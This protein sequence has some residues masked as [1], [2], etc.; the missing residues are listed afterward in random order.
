MQYLEHHGLGELMF[1]NMNM[2]F[3]ESVKRE[4]ENPNCARD[5]QA[6]PDSCGGWGDLAHHYVV[7]EP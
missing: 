4:G 6:E 2:M 7:V 3:I 1:N 5:R